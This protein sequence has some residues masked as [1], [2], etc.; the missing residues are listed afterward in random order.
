MFENDVKM[1]G[2][3]EES[4]N[5]VVIDRHVAISYLAKDKNFGDIFF[6][7]KSHYYIDVTAPKFR[8]ILCLAFDESARNTISLKRMESLKK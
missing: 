5:L 3:Q 6:D 1:H 8:R 2:T 4:N 7:C